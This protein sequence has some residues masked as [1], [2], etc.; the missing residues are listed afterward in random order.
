[1]DLDNFFGNSSQ[2]L[3]QRDLD[4]P[5]GG[6]G[7]ARKNSVVMIIDSNNSD[8]ALHVVNNPSPGII[9]P[10]RALEKN[11]GDSEL[12]NGSL[13]AAVSIDKLQDAPGLCGIKRKILALVPKKKTPAERKLLFYLTSEPIALTAIA[14]D[15]SKHPKV[16]Y[17]LKI[18][19]SSS[20]LKKQPLKRTNMAR[21]LKLSQSLNFEKFQD[22]VMEIVAHALDLYMKISKSFSPSHARFLIQ[23]HYSPMK[24]MKLC[25]IM[26]GKQKILQYRYSYAH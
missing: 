10:P 22:S 21:I 18:A 8:E 7:K 12:S 20:E 11:L 5:Q 17:H 2:Q 4:M 23:L 9:E 25:W 19:S 16:T 14:E 24:I 1:V 6:R 3:S 15:N 13:P 26:S